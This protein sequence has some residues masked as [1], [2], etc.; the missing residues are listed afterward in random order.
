M[1]VLEAIKTR[2]SVNR[3]S[4]VVPSREDIEALL[5]AAVWAPNHRFTQPWKFY[6][7]AGDER[8][9]ISSQLA[10]S[11]AAH[12]DASTP[13]GKQRVEKAGNMFLQAPVVIA[14]TSALSEDDGLELEDCAATW[15]A[16]QNM[17]L[18]AWGKGIAS[19]VRTPPAIH[20][21]VLRKLLGVGE[22]CQI[23]GLVFLGYAGE[24][25]VPP[26]RARDAETATW[27]GW[28]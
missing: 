26:P 9:R 25:A 10:K 16:V 24:N 20:G 7:V 23:V 11:V 12:V 2:R 1:D 15:M 19:K 14:V 3:M 28:S 5:E 17:I 27:L 4:D 6:V 8:E 21:P 18:A 22:D 13:E